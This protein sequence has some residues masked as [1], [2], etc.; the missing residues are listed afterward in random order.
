MGADQ[1]LAP[2]EAVL[3]EAALSG[4]EP[5]EEDGGV[6]LPSNRLRESSSAIPVL[7]PSRSNPE[8]RRSC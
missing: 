2:N 5:P 7:G 4:L 8:A 3:S 6:G 1:N